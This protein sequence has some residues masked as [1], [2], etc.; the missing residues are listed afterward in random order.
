MYLPRI[1]IDFL[2]TEEGHSPRTVVACLMD[3]RRGTT[4]IRVLLSVCGD[5]GRPLKPYAI[6]NVYKLSL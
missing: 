3:R 4:G 1:G 6:W 5:C 2:G